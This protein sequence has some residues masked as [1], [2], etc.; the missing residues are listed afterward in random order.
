MCQVVSGGGGRVQDSGEGVPIGLRLAAF[1][2]RNRE[3]STHHEAP[4][5]SA[6]PA[7][8]SGGSV[9]TSSC[10]R[11][12]RRDAEIIESSC[13]R[14]IP[15]ALRGGFWRLPLR[16]KNPMAFAS[17]RCHSYVPQ[18]IQATERTQRETTDEKNRRET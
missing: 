9:L 18:A 2:N 11:L 3:Q 16:K 14:R 15:V 12:K 5:L 1:P 10:P 7:H 6:V 8:P 4:Y 17:T 13:S